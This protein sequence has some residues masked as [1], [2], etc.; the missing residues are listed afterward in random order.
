MHEIYFFFSG[1]SIGL[2]VGPLLLRAL[3]SCFRSP[4]GDPFPRP[5]SEP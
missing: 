5:G 1:L 4:A 3:K 2:L